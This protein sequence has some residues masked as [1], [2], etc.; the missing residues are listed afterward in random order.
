MIACQSISLSIALRRIL[1]STWSSASSLP[2]IFFARP[3][4]AVRKSLTADG[5]FSRATTS[6]KARA[7]SRARTASWFGRYTLDS[8]C[9]MICSS[10]KP[11]STRDLRCSADIGRQ[12]NGFSDNFQSSRGGVAVPRWTGRGRVASPLP[13]GSPASQ[14]PSSQVAG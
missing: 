6:S 5:P 3:S 14:R 12:P 7:N 1:L 13:K 8:S 2:D 9:S 4:S 11:A 10:V